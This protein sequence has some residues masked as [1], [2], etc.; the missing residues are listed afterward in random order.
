MKR[1][2]YTLFLFAI[3]LLGLAQSVGNILDRYD[4]IY[5]G[6]SPVNRVFTIRGGKVASELRLD[7]IRGEIS[8]AILLTDGHMLLAH[9]R[10]VTEIDPDGTPAWSYAAPEGTEIHTVQPVGT[11]KIVFVQCGI[12]A[13]AVVMR[14]PSFEII[15]EWE[16]PYN[17][18]GSVHGQFRNARLTPQGTL[19]IANMGMGFVSEYSADGTELHRWPFASPWSVS[20]LDNGAIQIVGSNGRIRE[21]NRA[22]DILAEFDTRPMGARSTQKAVNLPDGN[23]IVNNWHNEWRNGVDT[24][25]PQAV[26]I[27]RQG[28]V[29]AKLC[30]WTD[31]AL[32]ASTTIQ[33]LSDPVDR[34][35]LHFSQPAPGVRLLEGDNPDPSIV[36]QGDT[37]Y[38]VHSSFIYTPGLVVYKSTDLVNWTPCSTAL[39]EYAGDVWAPDIAIHD[40]RFYIYFPTLPDGSAKKTNMV[41]WADSPEGPWS[42]P[43]DLGIR[44]ID[45]EHVVDAEGNRYL[46]LSAGDLH[47]LSTDGTRLTG[48]PV[49]IYNGWEIPE[50]WDI[51]SFSLEGINI[52]KIGEWYY[53]LAAE[54]GTSGPP[55]GHMVVQARARDIKGPWE[56]A[57]SNPLLRTASPAEHWWSQGHGSIVDTPDGKLYMVYHA[58]EKDFLTLGRQCLIRPVEVGDDGW[59]RL[60]EES[61]LEEPV[62]SDTLGIADFVWQTYK[63]S[64]EPRFTITPDSIV[65]TC[66]GASPREGSPLL[67]RAGDH[68][69]E[70]EAT[71]RLDDPD[72]TAALVAYYDNTSHFG[73]GIGQGS[74]LRY[75]RGAVSRQEPKVEIPVGADG[76]TTVKLRLRSTDNIV[77]GDYS[78][79]GGATW[80]HYPWGFDMQGYHHNTLA[81][82]LSVRPGIY[83]GGSGRVT[84]TDLVYRR[85]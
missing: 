40:G 25:S 56:N 42:K 74:L 39:P 41:V 82:F 62:R 16:L 60:A 71:V 3:P 21:I 57:P 13:K 80:H 64:L 31:P 29:V 11:D 7:S 75:R 63:E 43:V 67:A 6:E 52:R 22:G 51:E 35:Q 4:F 18:R 53:L 23:I 27:D 85:R 73:L 59:L 48:D 32:G 38:M 69:Y 65:I 49:I 54:G 9:Q 50:E 10:G 30:S 46:L 79:D 14:V 45:P 8:D 33:L 68:S 72:A 1:L 61:G 17:A 28:N 20:Q 47:P 78:T 44:G 58:Y 66:K 36:R 70:L 77:T 76:S 19:L 15:S 5:A 83:A 81:G 26:E 24:T 12:P 37:Y 84:V 34:T 55:T 2:I